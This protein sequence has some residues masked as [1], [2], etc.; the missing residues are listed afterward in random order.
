MEATTSRDGA[1]LPTKSPAVGRRH[2]P[3]RSGMARSPGVTPPIALVIR[4]ADEADGEF[5]LIVVFGPGDAAWRPEVHL[6]ADG[7]VLR[8]TYDEILLPRQAGRI[9]HR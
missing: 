9:L 7:S 6:D 2:H 3:W 1:S 8:L 4:H 5:P